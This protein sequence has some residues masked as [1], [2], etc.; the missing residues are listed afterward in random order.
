MTDTIKY[1]KKNE[2]LSFVQD[3]NALTHK[4]IIGDNYDV[5]LNLLVEYRGKIDVI[6]IDPPY[7]KD[8]M[9]EFAKNNYDN[10][11]TR[12]NLLSLLYPR[13]VLARQLLSENGVIFCSI[14]DKNQAYV[15]G[16]F[17][18][19]FG[20]NNFISNFIWKKK[21][22]TTNVEGVSASA[23]TEYILCYVRKNRDSISNRITLAESRTYPF[24][25][26]EGNYRKTVIEKK[27]EGSYERRTMVFPILDQLPRAGKRWQIGEGTARDLESKNRFIKE[28]GIIKLKIYDF[29]D[30]DSYSAWP[31]LLL[32]HGTTESAAKELRDILNGE[33]NFENPKP[34]LLIRSLIEFT[35]LPKDTGIVLDFFSGSGTTGHAVLELNKQDNGKRRFILANVNEVTNSNPNGIVTDVTSKRLKRV[36]SG[37]CYDGTEEFDWLKE[38]IPYGDNL[39]IFNIE[40]ISPYSNDAFEKIDETLY[41]KEK[42]EVKEKI[43]WVCENFEITQKKLEENYV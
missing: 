6:Y 32:N 7:G 17:D 12:D 18:E 31:N 25:D 23:L 35:N 24:S 11:I 14:D 28:D 26:N 19:V 34:T 40:N 22:T 4:L 3:K 29:E 20:E 5:L 2:I 8:S 37:N 10:A 1:F 21:G 42:L 39:D 16:L 43:K 36:M 33:G 15:K 30:K 27:N 13:L 38:N 9:G 41:G